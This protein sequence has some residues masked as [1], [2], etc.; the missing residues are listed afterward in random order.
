MG[1]TMRLYNELIDAIKLPMARMFLQRQRDLPLDYF[2]GV[3][4]V[5]LVGFLM[6]HF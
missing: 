4:V 2:Q 6:K 5:V 1:L 3:A